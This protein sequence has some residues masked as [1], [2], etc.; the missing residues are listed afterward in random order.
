MRY[1]RNEAVRRNRGDNTPRTFEQYL[2]LLRKRRPDINRRL[3]TGEARELRPAVGEY[4]GRSLTPGDSFT[5]AG[6]KT[7]KFEI[8][9]E[10][11]G[12]EVTTRPDGVTLDSSGKLEPNPVLQEHKF[13]RGGPEGDEIPD[14]DQMKAQR[15]FAKA[16][17]GKH[18]VSISA[19]TP[20]LDAIPPRPR[21][22]LEL[23]EQSDVVFVDRNTKKVSRVWS[24]EHEKWK[25][26]E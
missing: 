22:S 8:T 1:E 3:G 6:G 9:V 4:V 10:V 19:E 26:P 7:S 17:G 14:T 24:R 16:N 20:Q 23:G 5:T 25:A 2:E 18:V 12:K 11:E 15:T 21:P 13:W